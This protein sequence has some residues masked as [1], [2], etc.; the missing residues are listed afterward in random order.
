MSERLKGDGFKVVDMDLIGVA[1][2]LDQVKK[3]TFDG[4]VIIVFGCDAAI[5]NVKKLVGNKKVMAALD[6]VGIGT[7]DKKGNLSLVKEF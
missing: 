2:D 5:Y 4:D 7:R 1:C 3:E 6:T